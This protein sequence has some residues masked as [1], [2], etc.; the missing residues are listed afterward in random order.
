MKLIYNICCFLFPVLAFCQQAGERSVPQNIVWEAKKPN[1]RLLN[2]NTFTFCDSDS[3]GKMPIN[4]ETIKNQVLDG[5]VDQFGTESGIYISTRLS[6]VHLITDIAGTPQKALVCNG[7]ASLGG[8][9]ML[10]IAINQENDM[11]V[12]VVDKIHK[13]NSN[14]CNIENTIDLGLNGS[15]ITSLSF[16][17]NHNMYLGGFDAYVYRMNNGSYGIMNPWHNFGNGVAA[18]DFVMCKDK[19]YIAW[20][21]NGGCRLY[22]VTVDNN[23]NYISHVDLGSL[24]DNTFGLA[25]ELGHLYGVTPFQLYEINCAPLAFTQVLNNTDSN[26]D[27]YGAA[28]KNEAVN[29]EISVFESLQNAQNNTDSLPSTWTNT[30]AF[31]QTVYVVIRNTVNNQTATVPVQLVVNAAPSYNNPGRLVHCESDP[32]ANV[33]NI[34]ATETSIKGAQTNVVVTYHTT[35]GN[36]ANNVSALPDVYDT[37]GNATKIYTRLTNAVTGCFSTFDFTLDIAPKP[38]FNQPKDLTVCA[39]NRAFIALDS[40]NPQILNGQN[41][42]DIRITFHNSEADALAGVYPLSVPYSAAVGQ[43]EIFV[44]IENTL[45]GC[46]DTGSFNVKVMAE[47]QNFPVTYKVETD[48]WSDDENAIQVIATG[49][50]DYSLDGINYQDSPYFAHL[51]VGDYQLHVRDKDNCSVSIKDVFLLMYPKFFTPNG[52]GY[53]DTWNIILASNEPEMKIEIYD[54]YGKVIT[55]LSGKSAGWDGSLNGKELPSSDYW[56]TVTRQNGKTF[57]GHFTLKR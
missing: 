9:G 13:L 37:N 19:M 55:A 1:S 22:E 29:F 28:G 20:R 21:I 48:D 31:S 18:G 26:D 54:R 57:K 25:S 27:W 16:D 24:P 44:R 43:K 2:P 40:Q 12:A 53:H 7:S 11:Y 52:D 15:S 49:N 17:R 32:N 3:D 34:R 33:F 42:E 41:P 39:S 23:T 35:A 56:F 38:D 8:Y 30:Q 14:N 47:N 5:N 46:F 45:S 10:D 50:Y 6:K 36:A 51:S 4:L